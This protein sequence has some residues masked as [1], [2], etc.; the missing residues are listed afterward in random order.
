M[1]E[2]IDISSTQNTAKDTI[3]VVEDD[4]GV[5]MLERRR[6]E[7]AGYAVVCATTAEE[8][9]GYVEQGVTLIVLDQGLPDA[10]GLEFYERLKAAGHDLPVIIVTGLSDEATVVA[11]LRAG[12]CDFVIKS[13][14]YLDYL[15]EA[16]E[17]VLRQSRL[18]QRLQESE[19]K[20]R[21]IFENAVVGIYQASLDGRL[22][23]VNPAM[24]RMFGYG[25]PEEMISAVTDTRTQLWVSAE[26][27]AKYIRFLQ[28]GGTVVGAEAWMR[29]KNGSTIWVSLSVRPLRNADGKLVGLEGTFQD[30]TE[31]K[32]AEEAMKEAREAAEAANRAKSEF[33][34]NMSHEI[35]TP[36]NG[37]IGMTELLLDTELPPKQREYAETVR[38]SAEHLLTII[39]DILDFSKIE[40]GEMRIETTQF[41][42]RTMV[43]NVVTLLA[44]AARA[45]GLKLTSLIKYD[46]PTTLGGDPGRLR[47]VLTN[48]IGNAIKF[49]EQ[50]EA[51]LR[52]G[53][54]EEENDSLVVRFEVEDTGIGITQEQQARLFESFT[55]AD[56][57][58][59]RHYG[60]TGLGLAISK[61]L[62]ELMGGQIGVE[63]SSGKGSTF[64]FTVRLE[65]Q[66][67]EARTA[68]SVPVDLQDLRVLIVDDNATNR[69]ILCEQT[70]SWKMR[71]TSVEDGPRALEALRSAA[72]RGAPF[73]MAILDMQMPAMEGMELARK[74]KADP[75]LA[76]T[77]LV[78][79]T[80][81]G[82]RG[83]AKE[84]KRAGI[85]AYLTKPIT[86]SELYD[87]LATVM[88]TSYQVA[89][90]DPKPDERL[91][92]RHSIREVKAR[93]RVRVLVAEDNPVNQKVA[94]RMLEKLGYQVDVV[95]DGREAL[96]ALE[97][98]PYAAVLMDV[99]MPEMDGYEATAEIRRREGEELHT[100]VIAMTANAMQGDR[101]KVLEAG[102]DDYVPKPVKSEELDAV[103]KRWLRKEVEEEPR[104]PNVD[105]QP[106]MPEEDANREDSEDPL[107]RA[108]LEGLR[109]LGGSELITELG[110]AFS[111]VTPPQLANLRVAVEGGDAE[112]VERIAHTLKGSSAN[113]GARRMAGI[114]EELQK[115]KVS[116]DLAEALELLDRLEVEFER[117]QRALAAEA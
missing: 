97:H 112:A 70:A 84:A 6:L 20:Y 30:I 36:M 98:S 63:S 22:L 117:V 89:D 108:T 39:N 50:G 68:E 90:N 99:Q 10:T 87:A 78:L 7:R 48:L 113:M 107:D 116:T 42:L 94:L 57:S 31:R 9:L 86:Q 27:R 14:E 91:V 37:V 8:A 2:P 51:I 45:K 16:V 109:E 105:A 24:A 33:L 23:M 110:E 80:S 79:L 75:T 65:S 29:H 52:V 19:E 103:L 67:A 5:S 26:E 92:T 83:D 59:T 72:G 88:G 18:E 38:L 40:A 66:P 13:P 82:Q 25:S 35:R 64:W 34:A 41:D 74:I 17:R 114:C 49:T 95:G 21:L 55:Q 4:P 85:E 56:A 81:M 60:G 61:Q 12:V 77:R 47:Q 69:K 96:E 28:E 58:T 44:E 54:D 106:V 43:E 53:L 101:E 71:A 11:A 3:L 93:S 46:V 76:P 111:S 115:P 15:S 102:M 73:D 62:V 100:P 104:K 32:R 1:L